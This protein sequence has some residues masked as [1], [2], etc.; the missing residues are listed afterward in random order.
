VPIEYTIE[1]GVVWSHATGVL[2]DAGLLAH[3]RRLQADPR[4]AAEVP[5]LFDCTT[6]SALELTGAGVREVA[7]L[8]RHDPELPRARVAVVVTGTAAFGMARM[9]G[10]LRDDIDV[11]IFSAREA[12]TAWLLGS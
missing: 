6:I 8:L 11:Q 10:L 1:D 7:A 3:V 4:H 9:Y 2:D 12:A 5:E